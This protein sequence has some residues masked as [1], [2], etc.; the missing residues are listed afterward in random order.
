ML[1][2][3]SHLRQAPL[4]TM[5]NLAHSGQASEKANQCLILA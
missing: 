1:P 4:P 5:V 2:H 3:V